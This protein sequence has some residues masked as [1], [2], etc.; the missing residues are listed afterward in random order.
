MFNSGYKT[1]NISSFMSNFLGVTCYSMSLMMHQPLLLKRPPELPF[2]W[3][4][5]SGVHTDKAD[6]EGRGWQW[7]F[8]VLDSFVLMMSACPQPKCCPTH[9]MP[10]STEGP[11]CGHDGDSDCD[12]DGLGWNP[13]E[14]DSLE[15]RRNHTLVTLK[16]EQLPVFT[17]P[18]SQFSFNAICSL[19]LFVLATCSVH[20]DTSWL[21]SCDS[22]F[23][24][25]RQHCGVMKSP[26]SRARLPGFER[27]CH[28]LLSLLCIRFS[29]VK[30]GV[31][32][33]LTAHMS[34][35][36]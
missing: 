24:L 3:N 14:H 16:K 26:S 19:K 4:F 29:S 5:S 18:C 35:W 32:I 8:T 1:G 36:R 15:R 31:L 21:A 28:C 17:D 6:R 20:V 9:R 12:W 27:L 11:A 30:R 25:Q 10:H 33:W 22:P 23:H 7:C 2:H 34:M 13:G